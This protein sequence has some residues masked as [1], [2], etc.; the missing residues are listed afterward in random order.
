MTKQPAKLT[1]PE[2]LE[3][4]NDQLPA[5]RARPGNKYEAVLKA[6]KPGQ[7]IKCK[8]EEV[9][10]VS[11]AMRKYIETHDLQAVVRTIKDYGD[12]HGRVWMLAKEGKA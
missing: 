3:I 6:L 5:H 12:G 1:N 4:C 9:G 2:T 11:G 10:R 7:A 8:P